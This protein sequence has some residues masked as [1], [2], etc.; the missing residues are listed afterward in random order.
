MPVLIPPPSYSQTPRRFTCPPPGA[1]FPLP[2]FPD[3]HA[4]SQD[5]P[6]PPAL[7]CLQSAALPS[8]F[9][10]ALGHSSET[11]AFMPEEE[12]EGQESRGRWSV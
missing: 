8:S 12:K 2:P 10:S 6:L 9:P 3:H 4:S 5:Q 7:T 1:L 11:L